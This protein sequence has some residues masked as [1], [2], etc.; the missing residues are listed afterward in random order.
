MLTNANTVTAAQPIR[1]VLADGHPVTLDGLEQLF[2]GEEFA[3]L[4]RCTDG[5][6]TVRT[7][8]THRPDILVLDFRLARKDGLAVI[9]ELKRE[10]LPTRIVLL[11]SALEEDQ[12]GEAIRLGVRGVVLKEMPS[13]LLLQCIRKVHG[14]EPW[15][16]K[17]SVGRLLEKLLRREIASRQFALDLTGREL[18]IVRLVATGLRNKEIA[19]RLFVR[20]G[21]VKIHLHNIYRKLNVNSRMALT[22]Y[23]QKRGFV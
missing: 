13:A 12:I 20:E 23:A 19:T 18:E 8:R 4:A 9:R 15:V 22:L 21:T 16:E 2:R 10:N 7:V 17:R 5:E 14:G 1:I 6:D 11:S 3:V